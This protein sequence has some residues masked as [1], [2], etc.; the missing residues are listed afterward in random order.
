MK[1]KNK[2][3]AEFAKE[4]LDMLD[5]VVRNQPGLKEFIYPIKKTI[6]ELRD[7]KNRVNERP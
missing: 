4:I 5:E 7:K 3:I 6:R 2:I 1:T